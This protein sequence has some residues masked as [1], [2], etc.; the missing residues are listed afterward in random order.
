MNRIPVQNRNWQVEV[1]GIHFDLLFV[2]STITITTSKII[3]THQYQDLSRFTS[4]AHWKLLIFGL[5][6]CSFS[7]SDMCYDM[8]REREREKEQFCK[9][10]RWEDVRF[11]NQSVDDNWQSMTASM[12][13]ALNGKPKV[14]HYC[15]NTSSRSSNKPGKWEVGHELNNCW[16]TYFCMGAN[17]K[18]WM[19]VSPW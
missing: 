5:K 4:V 11:L 3:S 17:T 13:C 12:C 2:V 10:C 19:E 15:K 8:K 16:S 18:W 1:L 6:L 14:H 7:A 9:L